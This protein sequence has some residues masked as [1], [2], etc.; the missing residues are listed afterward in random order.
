M[1]IDTHCHLDFPDFE[2]D[3]EEVIE[4]TLKE[5][6]T[7]IVNIGTCIETSRKSLG[8]S[9]RYPF[10]HPTAGIHPAHVNE[11]NLTSS[12]KEIER[13]AVNGRIAGIGETGLDFHYSR[14]GVEKQKDFFRAHIETAARL[15]LPLIVHQRDSRDE[16]MEIFD[17]SV[18]PEKVVFHCFGGDGVLAAYCREKG[19]YISFTGIITFKKTDDVK[20]IAANYPLER[21]MAETDAPYLAPVPFRGKRNDPSKVRYVV[22]TIASVRGMDLVECAERILLNSREFFNLK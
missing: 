3:R 5:G 9:E 10:I 19:F 2:P 12:M 4:N 14:D 1:Y 17:K 7:D 6:I 16:V 8:L 22:E 11:L 21:I 20:K 13:I 15:N 18:L